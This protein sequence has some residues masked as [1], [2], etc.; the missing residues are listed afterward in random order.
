MATS[1]IRYGL[2]DVFV[3]DH[4]LNDWIKAITDQ[5]DQLIASGKDIEWLLKEC[6]RWCEIY[7]N[8]PPGLKD[9]E[10]DDALAVDSE[11]R[12]DEIVNVLNSVLNQSTTNNYDLEIAKNI[13]SKILNEL[14]HK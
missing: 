3:K 2:N 12:K 7:E 13:C 4:E 8:Y 6:N 10:F 14:F 11:N 9:I 5:F 1:S